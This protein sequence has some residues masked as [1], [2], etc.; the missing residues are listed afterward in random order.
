MRKLNKHSGAQEQI[1]KIM[2]QI[3]IVNLHIRALEDVGSFIYKHNRHEEKIEANDYYDILVKI[4]VNKWR[5]LFMFG[6]VIDDETRDRIKAAAYDRFL[7][8]KVVTRF[9]AE[10]ELSSYLEADETK[11]LE[12]ARELFAPKVMNQN[13]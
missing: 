6:L 9:I 5:D 11:F 2:E 7:K 1:E 4:E 10:T 12:M 3:E 13:D 8:N